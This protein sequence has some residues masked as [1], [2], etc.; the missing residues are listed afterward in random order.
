[1]RSDRPKASIDAVAILLDRGYGKPAQ[2]LIGDSSEDP[3][4]IAVT[5]ARKSVRAI[6]SLAAIARASGLSGA[7]EVDRDSPSG[8]TDSDG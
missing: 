5:D 2:P 8:A 1:M 3:I 4:S 6:T 7:D